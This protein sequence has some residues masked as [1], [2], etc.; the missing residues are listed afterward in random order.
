MAV[1]AVW[2]DI[3]KR[4]VALLLITRREA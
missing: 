4:L 3:F 2:S 1:A